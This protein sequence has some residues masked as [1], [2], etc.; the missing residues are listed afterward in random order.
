MTTV[1][2]TAVIGLIATYDV[3]ELGIIILGINRKSR[4]IA[5]YDVFELS[6]KKALKTFLNRLIATYDVF[7]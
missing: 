1:T 3:F 2:N 7:E 4:L 5:T 6:K